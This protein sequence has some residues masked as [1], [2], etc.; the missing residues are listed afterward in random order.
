VGGKERF[1]ERLKR[2]REEVGR[3]LRKAKGKELVVLNQRASDL[4]FEIETAGEMPVPE[5]PGDGT[6]GEASKRAV[7]GGKL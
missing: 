1:L 3:R 2:S 4:D 5:K 7:G 6:V